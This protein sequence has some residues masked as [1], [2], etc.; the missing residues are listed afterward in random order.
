[1][2]YNNSA[3]TLIAVGHLT[4]NIFRQLPAS[5]TFVQLFSITPIFF[6]LFITHVGGSNGVN[7]GP[8]K[9]WLTFL[10]TPTPFNPRKSLLTT[11]HGVQIYSNKKVIKYISHSSIRASIETRPPK[12]HNLLRFSPR[13][14]PWH[15]MG[16]PHPPSFASFCDTRISSI[17]VIIAFKVVCT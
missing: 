17:K 4:R 12:L 15:F 8:M 7:T 13:F 2:Y 14:H 3:N 5:I 6:W 11:K 10:K 1:M 9:H 16:L